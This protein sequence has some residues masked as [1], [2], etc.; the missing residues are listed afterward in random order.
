MTKTTSQKPLIGVPMDYQESGGYSQFPWYV[1]RENYLQRVAEVG[2]IPLA[3]SNDHNLID[4]YL[5]LI[6]GLLIT[7]AGFD[8]DPLI[9]GDTTRHPT[10]KT[11]PKRTDFELVLARKALDKKMPILG[12][13]GGEQLINVAL[14][15]TLIQHI[16]DEISGDIP[17]FAATIT[18]D[19]PCHEIEITPNSKLHTIVEKNKMHVNS[20]HHQAVKALGRGLRVNAKS[21]EGLVEGIELEDYP[22]CLGVQWHPEFCVDP[23]DL[24]IFKAFINAS[25]EY[26]KEK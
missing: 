12:I 2:G 22:F 13:C 9:Y 5:S 20:R 1:L 26:R 23:K 10:I 14:G 24:N 15:G 4:D 11:N 16:G 17:H 19:L 21:P 18:A 8:I 7:G 3:L 6:D 25:T